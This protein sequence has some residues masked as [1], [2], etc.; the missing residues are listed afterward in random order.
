[1]T[2]IIELLPKSKEKYTIGVGPKTIDNKSII[3]GNVSK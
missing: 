3:T 2:N 1:M